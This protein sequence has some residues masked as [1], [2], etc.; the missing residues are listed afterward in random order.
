[1]QHRGWGGA[2]DGN[3]AIEKPG[4]VG[5]STGQGRPCEGKRCDHPHYSMNQQQATS[6]IL[7]P[8]I[9]KE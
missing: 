6:M 3:Q 8:F 9:R 5:A 1:M 2:G 7:W 4:D